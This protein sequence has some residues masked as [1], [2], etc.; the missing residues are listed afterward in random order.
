MGS[1]VGIVLDDVVAACYTNIVL[2]AIF[3]LVRRC[4]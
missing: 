1:G 2:H 3:F 4:A